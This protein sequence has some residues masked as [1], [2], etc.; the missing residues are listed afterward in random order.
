[1]RW[2]KAKQK[3][4]IN[5]DKQKKYNKKKKDRNLGKDT[6]QR[7]STYKIDCKKLANE[8]E[9]LPEFWQECIVD[10]LGT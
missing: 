2:D 9:I 1:M 7:R 6:P 10:F 5:I 8:S 4:E 3:S